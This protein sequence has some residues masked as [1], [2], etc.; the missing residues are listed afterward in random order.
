MTPGRGHFWPKGLNLKK[1]GKGPLDGATYQISLSRHCGFRQEEFLKFSS[2]K[3]IFSL[4]DLDNYATDH[5][6]LN[7]IYL[8][9]LPS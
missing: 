2:R 6:H 9:F 3:S 4:C 8:S 1:L 7:N 5:N